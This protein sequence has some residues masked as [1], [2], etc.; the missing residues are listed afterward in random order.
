MA[1]KLFLTKASSVNSLS[2]SQGEGEDFGLKPKSSHPVS[3]N[4]KNKQNN[5]SKPRST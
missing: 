4:G 1:K 5:L 3:N 2:V